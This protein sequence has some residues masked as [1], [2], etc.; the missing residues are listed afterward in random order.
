MVDSYF[1]KLAPPKGSFSNLKNSHTS[2]KDHNPTLKETYSKQ[3]SSLLLPK[4]LTRT[5]SFLKFTGLII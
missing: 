5:T 1:G 3:M 2:T 4:D